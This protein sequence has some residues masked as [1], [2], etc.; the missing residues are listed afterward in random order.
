MSHAEICP[1]CK[2]TGKLEKRICH[3]CDGKGWVTVGIDYP[4]A[5]Y[6]EPWQEFK[7][8]RDESGNS[9]LVRCIPDAKMTGDTI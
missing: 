7:W 2:G 5:H 4:P 3:G 8:A 6:S 9:I 1:I